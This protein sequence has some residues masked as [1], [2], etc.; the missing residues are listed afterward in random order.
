MIHNQGHMTKIRENTTRQNYFDFTSKEEAGGS[1]EMP[2]G[3][4]LFLTTMMLSLVVNELKQ[5]LALSESL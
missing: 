1:L 5:E 3:L 2:N 4:S